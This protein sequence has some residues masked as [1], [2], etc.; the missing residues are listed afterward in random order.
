MVSYQCWKTKT[1]VSGIIG[2]MG[3][4][5]EPYLL[6]IYKLIKTRTCHANLPDLGID[7]KM[8]SVGT[9]NIRSRELPP[10]SAFTTREEPTKSGWSDFANDIIAA[11]FF[12]GNLTR[13]Q[14]RRRNHRGRGKYK[15]PHRW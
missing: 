4:T 7:M 15:M 10:A 8:P 13:R 14:V 12:P 3:K 2:R 1:D 6:D 9:F 5:Q 11:L